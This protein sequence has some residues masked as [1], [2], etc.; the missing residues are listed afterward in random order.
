MPETKA[1]DAYLAAERVRGA[2]EEEPHANV[3]RL[4]VSAGVCAIDPSIDAD[5][6]FRRADAALYVAKDRGR[7]IAVV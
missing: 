3:G 6:L 4:T 5:E 7:N 1:G 2:V